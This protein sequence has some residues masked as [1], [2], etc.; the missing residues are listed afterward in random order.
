MHLAVDINLHEII[1]A[2][3]SALNVTDGKAL[4]TFTQIDAPKN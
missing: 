2:E 3:L 1:V 4:R